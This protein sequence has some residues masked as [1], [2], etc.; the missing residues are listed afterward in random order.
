MA[1]HDSSHVDDTSST[2]NQN[3]PVK[4]NNFHFAFAINNVKTI[5]PVTL[6]YDS[7]LYLSW[8][9]LFKVQ[10]RVHNVLDHII[11]PS[12]EKAVQAAATFKASDSDL[13]NRLDVVVL[14][15]MY[16]TVSQ[17]ILNSILVIDDSAEQCWNRI[18]A[19]FNDNKHSRAVQL[20]NQFSNTHLEDFASTKAYFNRLKLLS[21]QLANVDSPVSNTRLVLKMISGLTDAYVGFVT[22]IQ[23]HNP[24]PTFCCCQISIRTRRIDHSPT[25]GSRFLLLHT[26]CTF[27]RSKSTRQNC[28]Q[29][30]F[31][32][33]SIFIASKWKTAHS[34][35]CIPLEINEKSTC[36]ITQDC[37]RAQLLRSASLFI[38]D[39]APMMNRYCFEAFD[40]TMKDL[41]GKVEKANKNKPFGGK[42]VVLGDSTDKSQSELKEFA[43]WILKIGDGRIGGDE[44]GEVVINIA[45]DLCVLQNDNPLLSLVDFVYPNIVICLGKTNFFEDEA[46]MA[47]TLEVVQEV[48]DFVLSMIPSESQD[49]LSCDTPCKFDED[50]S[51]QNEWFTS[52][53]LNDIQCSGIPNHRLTLK[54]GVPVMLLHN[55]DQA[56]GL[57]NGTRLQVTEL[58]KN[59]IKGTII[60]GKNVGEVVYIPRMDL[61]PSDS[62][63]P[64]KFCRSQFPICLCF[65]MTINKSQG[66]SLAKVELYLPR[67]VF[68]H[69]QLYVAI[70]RVTT[71]KDLKMNIIVGENVLPPRFWDVV[72]SDPGFLGKKVLGWQVAADH[73]S[74]ATSR[75]TGRWSSVADHRETAGKYGS[76]TVNH[77]A[78][79]GGVLQ[80]TAPY[81]RRPRIAPY[82]RLKLD[83]SSS[84]NHRQT[85]LRNFSLPPSSH[86]TGKTRPIVPLLISLFLRTFHPRRSPYSHSSSLFT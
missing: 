27:G 85:R 72:I 61:V 82:H 73:R 67:P 25:R 20:E 7:N 60:S 68:T 37:H 78:G 43:D 35:F 42:V 71:K 1:D 22:Y 9:S 16:A 5:I 77:R 54:V 8:S 66:Q 46:I 52:E 70:S 49:F 12:D 36:N 21:D 41:M 13:W 44:N 26:S 4:K 64:F 74:S 18:A 51:V 19:M 76:T 56:W 80:R 10:V 63:L 58:G 34:T 2:S 30:C 57:C 79:A 62:G 31:E 69:G 15:W 47:P 6:D 28:N 50:H 33:N 53:F 83:P 55:N 48:N 84:H 75:R 32:R 65:A 17:D 86:T 3:T 29:C 23:Q 40:R 59:I 45:E 39:E 24:L 14:Q 11:P 81:H 38:W